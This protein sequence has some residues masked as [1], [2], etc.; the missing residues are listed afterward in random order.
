[1]VIIKGKQC[2]EDITRVSLDLNLNEIIPGCIMKIDLCEED[3]S[4]IGQV[5]TV[6]AK[7]FTL[8][9]IDSDSI[10]SVRE[11]T[12]TDF[13]SGKFRPYLIKL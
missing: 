5:Y 1:M 13:I 6:T 2:E 8:F 11:F 12:V 4:I 3:K 10:A 9:F 7:E